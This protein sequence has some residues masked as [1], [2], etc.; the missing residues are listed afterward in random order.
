MNTI[1]IEL[2]AE[3]RAR[4]DKILEALQGVNV[5]PAPVAEEHPVEEPFGSPD[6]VEEPAA[7]P[8]PKQYTLADV[9]SLV[10]ELAKPGSKKQPEAKAIVQSYAAKVSDIPADKYGEV[11]EKLNALKE[12]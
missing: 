2:C 11:M 8:A 3:D 5:K 12:A 6:P 7:E 4:L 10:Q 9:R 1:T